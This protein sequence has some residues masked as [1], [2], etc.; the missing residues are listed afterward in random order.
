VATPADDKLVILA[1]QTFSHPTTTT[2]TTTTLSTGAKNQNQ[3][4][5]QNIKRVSD[6]GMFFHLFC[7]CSYIS[8]SGGGGHC[9]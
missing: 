3:K 4:N 5:N 6:I 8:H 1:W 7:C 2:T 9:H